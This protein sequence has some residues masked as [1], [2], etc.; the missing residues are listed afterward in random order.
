[1]TPLPS[2]PMWLPALAIA[3]YLLVTFLVGVA[4]GRWPEKFRVGNRGAAIHAFAAGTYCTSWTFYGCIGNAARDGASF[5]AFFIGPSVAAIA[6]LILIPKMSRYAREEGAATVADLVALRF[7]NAPWFGVFVT[8]VIAVAVVPYLS[9]QF[10]AVRLS[11]GVLSGFDDAGMD[12]SLAVAVGLCTVALAFGG[13]FLDFTKPQSGLLTAAAFES[14][15]KL[16][17]FLAVG[18]FVVFGLF[19]GPG[20]VFRAAISDPALAPLATIAGPSG[21]GGGRFAAFLIVAGVNAILLPGQFHILV[22]RDPE[23]RY[24]R[25]HTRAFPLF[26][27]AISVLILPVALAGRL[28][29]HPVGSAD[30]ILLALPIRTGH[31]WLALLAFVGGFSAVAAM[32]MISAVA[33]GKMISGNIVIPGILRLRKSFH[34]YEVMLLSF[35]L[36]VV[37]TIAAAWAFDRFGPEGGPLMGT[38]VAAFGAL[39]QIAPAFF[40]GL[41]WR[42]A[43]RVGAAAGLLLGL[44][45]WIGYLSAPAV[46]EGLAPHGLDA[47]STAIFASLALNALGLLA[48]SWLFP[49]GPDETDAFDRGD[50]GAR[51]GHG[52]LH[53]VARTRHHISIE[54]AEAVVRRFAG[55]EKE[56]EVT[57]ITREIRESREKDG[58]GAAVHRQ[59]ELPAVVERL[60]TGTVGTVAAREIAREIFPYEDDARVLVDSLR[61]ME[62]DLEAT[63][64]EVTKKEEA[65]RERDR[66]LA[67]VVRSIDDGIVALDVEGRITAVNEGGVD[68]FGRAEE[69]LL[70]KDYSVLIVDSPVGEMRRV[71]SRAT[72]RIGKWRGEVEVNRGEK[73]SASALLSTSRVVDPKGETTGFVA[74]FKDLTAQKEMQKRMIQSEKLASLGQM[75]AGVA[76]EIRHPLGS[77]KMSARM[78]PASED[79]ATAEAIDSIREAVTSMEIIVNELLDYTR[80]VSLSLDIFDLAGI[81]KGAVFGL[82]DESEKRGVKVEVESKGDVSARVD[83]VRVKQVVGNVV[84]NAVEASPRGGTVRV[85]LS[86]GRRDT[87]RIAVS[88]AGE[89]MDEIAREKMFQPFFTTKAQGVGLG[90]AIVKRFVEMH[91]GEVVVESV[92][93]AG[94]T[95]TLVFPRIPFGG[96]R[97]DTL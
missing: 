10:R 73:G 42:G 53:P 64:G 19:D 97:R 95:V 4:G 72:Y 89:G 86:R 31:P 87:V 50:E 41:F 16:F 12:I 8:A 82:A 14:A 91:G 78:I 66:F 34:R 43:G 76:H 27:F 79:P 24:A 67:S 45:V 96:A 68:L 52:S 62:R 56:R 57:A 2:M 11:V 30:S 21:T 32:V 54:E 63:R 59:A 23:G 35:R 37:G 90:M 74:S 80:D 5:L 29:G 77:I 93:G 48:G 47:V 15:F 51:H 71:I 85:A 81:V 69:D 75:A 20:D 9:L 58:V 13:R 26:L 18:G 94:T 17:A 55:S 44:S 83:G 25:V 70:G 88:D 46:F 92:P 49:P 38:G 65:L 60:L 6:F 28:L 39:A 36:S 33:V 61:A 3:A 84:K 7:G 40:V 1:M 22:A